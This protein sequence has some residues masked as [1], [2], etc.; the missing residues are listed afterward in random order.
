MDLLGDL[1]TSQENETLGFIFCGLETK[2]P[3]VTPVTVISVDLHRIS[4]K[5]LKGSFFL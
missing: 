2:G 1:S 5:A 4:T 3:N